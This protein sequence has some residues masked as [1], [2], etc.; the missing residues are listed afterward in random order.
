MPLERSEALDDAEPNHP[1]RGPGAGR[2]GVHPL[3]ATWWRSL[4]PEEW[5]APTDCTGWDV[6]TMVLHVLGSGDAQASFREFAHQLRRGM[7]LNK[8]IDSHH[9]VDGMNEL[10]IRERAHLSDRRDRRAARGGGPEGGQGSVGHAASG[11]VRP[12]PLRA[13]DRMGAAQVPARRR[14]HPGRLGPPDRH[15]RGHRPP[16]APHAPTTTAAW[17]PTSSPNG[18]GSTAS[19]SSSCSTVPPAGSSARAWRVSGSRSTPWTSSAPSPAACPAPVSSATHY[20][21]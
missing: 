9:W 20:P 15:P 5:A 7:P 16:D 13:A 8:E 1:S 19:P 12:P 4:T 11:A 10:Q 18:P 17:S 21:L 6:R 3:R 14:I 2:G